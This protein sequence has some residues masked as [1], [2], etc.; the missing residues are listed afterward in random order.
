MAQSPQHLAHFISKSLY[1][2]IQ[3]AEILLVPPKQQNDFWC[4]IKMLSCDSNI[5]LFSIAPHL[6]IAPLTLQQKKLLLLTSLLHFLFW[7]CKLIL[8]FFPVLL[9]VQL[10]I[11][12]NLK[13]DKKRNYTKNEAKKIESDTFA[14]SNRVLSNIA[15]ITQHHNYFQTRFG[16]MKTI[17]T[18]IR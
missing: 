3:S 8:G 11:F 16:L 7:F 5:G 13:C 1:I 6:V 10:S 4:P 17:D 15:I 12:F 14:R 18:Y 2:I 9:S